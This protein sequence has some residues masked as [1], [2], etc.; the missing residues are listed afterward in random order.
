M[1]KTRAQILMLISEA[2]YRWVMRNEERARTLP[3]D[4]RGR[5][6]NEHAIDAGSTPEMEDELW[7]EIEAIKRDNR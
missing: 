2:H 7:E 5:D 1:P 3:L 6:Y 4:E